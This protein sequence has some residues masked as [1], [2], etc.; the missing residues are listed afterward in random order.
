MKDN[1][2]GWIEED[3]NNIL[4]NRIHEGFVSKDE[5]QCNGISYIVSDFFRDAII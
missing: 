2:V 5:Y 3:L 4:S 1:I